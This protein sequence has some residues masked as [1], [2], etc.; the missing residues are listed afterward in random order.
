MSSSY[1]PGQISEK[2]LQE[3]VESPSFWTLHSGM[4]HELGRM[5]YSPQ[6]F[7]SPRKHRVL[8]RRLS[9][10]CGC[11]IC[12]PLI[13]SQLTWLGGASCS[14]FQPLQLLFG[15]RPLPM[16]SLP[17]PGG[18]PL[19]RRGSVED[20]TGLA[21]SGGY[22]PKGSGRGVQVWSFPSSR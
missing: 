1:A 17:D 11:N 9:L 4:T 8:V 13:E 5:P 14:P 2:P 19:L 3:V 21:R 10:N 12:R 15:P 7:T 18:D 6:I 20:R 22:C 16:V